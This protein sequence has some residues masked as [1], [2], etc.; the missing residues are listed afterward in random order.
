MNTGELIY[1]DAVELEQRLWDRQ[2]TYEDDITLFSNIMDF[3]TEHKD[4]FVKYLN[5]KGE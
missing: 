3:V 2:E 4:E 5:E 1:K